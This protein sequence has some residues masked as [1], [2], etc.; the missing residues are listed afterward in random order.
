MIKSIT[1]IIITTT[2][3]APNATTPKKITTLRIKKEPIIE[4]GLKKLST[5]ILEPPPDLGEMPPPPNPTP[6]LT[7]ERT[8]QPNFILRT[9]AR[10][11]ID[12]RKIAWLLKSGKVSD[13]PYNPATMK[14]HFAR[15]L[16]DAKI[17]SPL[18]HLQLYYR[19]IKNGC[20]AV[21]YKREGK[22]N[23]GRAYP[24]GMLSL[25]S[26]PREIRN[27]I[28]RDDYADFDLS[29]AHASIF[30]NICSKNK[31]KCPTITRWVLKKAEVRKI[32]Y[33][34]FALDPKDKKSDK[35]IKD[36]INSTLYG[37]GQP[38]TDRWYKEHNLKGEMPSFHKDLTE[39]LKAINRE[40]IKSNEVL[41]EFARNT[42][43]QGDGKGKDAGWELTFLS[44]YAQEHEFR[45]VGGLMERLEKET[46]IFNHQ[47][48]TEKVVG[49]FEY[50][51]DGFKALIKNIVKEFDTIEKFVETL[52]KWS[53]ELGYDVC[54][55]RKEMETDLNWDGL[56]DDFVE[57]D[58]K[59]V[60]GDIEVLLKR[61]TDPMGM[62]TDA[63]LA[64]Y[65]HRE[66]AKDKNIFKEG[67]WKCWEDDNNRWKTHPT[68]EHP[69][70][71]ATIITE[72]I[73]TEILDE[74]AK[75]KEK[76]G[77]EILSDDLTEKFGDCEARANKFVEHIQDTFS[78]N[79]VFGA[80]ETEMNRDVAFDENGWLLGF[81]NGVFDLKEFKFRPY[82]MD[83]FVSMTT[84]W[85]FDESD[86]LKYNEACEECKE[87][88]GDIAKK[89]MEVE[90]VFAGI[91]PDIGTRTLL[92][93]LYASSLVGKCLEKFVIYNGAGRNGKGLLNEFW[94]TVLGE[95][96]Y[97]DLPYEIFTDPMNAT[98][99]NPA[100]AKIDKKRWCRAMEPKKTKKLCNATLKKL[101]GGEGLQAR[102]LYSNKTKV[103]NHGTFGIECNVRLDLQE[104]PQPN[105][106]EAERFIDILFPNR[107]T[108]F[109]EE[110]NEAEGVFRCNPQLKEDAWR[111]A[112]RSAMICIIL[113]HLKELVANDFR[114]GDFVPNS[115]KDRTKAYLSSNIQIHRIMT[116]ICDAV[117]VNP[118]TEVKNIPCVEVKDLVIAI[119]N[120]IDDRREL[121]K[122]CWKKTAIKD[123][124]ATNGL[125][126]KNYRADHYYHDEMGNKKHARGAML[127][128]KLK[129]DEDDSQ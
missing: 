2:M 12:R 34:A 129:G 7:L 49:V 22:K 65:I 102:M 97:N 99:G 128:F 26:L 72:R 113:R 104:D 115:V 56:T 122:D 103:I 23:W 79:K 123:F 100:L 28:A 76:I 89:I 101:T 98:T 61:L 11:V 9:T 106:A 45:L 70:Q 13:T 53:A 30:Q 77:D 59:E 92:K 36:L 10:E 24:V 83:D 108:E 29:T 75:I 62:K 4:K 66:L 46:E 78:R 73:P 127:W 16:K 110:V 119:H 19:K 17:N 84:G 112:H 86:W 111:H 37:G 8:T 87:L 71:L 44:Y 105:G 126:K 107:F 54:W 51:Y 69:R 40:L 60:K 88:E 43:K 68:S 32:F 58:E 39:E 6:P 95:Y 21:E 67:E 35:I 14:P 38:N 50:E 114:I 64:R 5:S 48:T 47:K 74:V 18:N 20:V 116:E 81:T 25:G 1:R 31:I 57:F 33:E 55:E 85:A 15:Q 117:E 82:E 52:N 91:M 80:C 124:F 90:E 120:W 96:G 42:K 3:D 109:E 125:Y 93:M 41:K 94:A 63:G 27:L 118:A 121:A